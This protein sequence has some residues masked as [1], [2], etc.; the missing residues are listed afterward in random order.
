MGPNITLKQRRPSGFSCLYGHHK[1]ILHTHFLWSICIAGLVELWKFIIR[2]HGLVRRRMMVGN[3]WARLICQYYAMF[4]ALICLLILPVGPQSVLNM[5]WCP[6][7][8][9]SVLSQLLLMTQSPIKR[10][11]HSYFPPAQFLFAL[12][13][14]VCPQIR[15]CSAF[16]KWGAIAKVVEEVF[17]FSRSMTSS[18]TGLSLARRRES[19]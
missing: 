19:N 10:I 7:C 12:A 6:Q 4:L 2:C 14:R 18:G 1:W 3:L 9:L 8:C 17:W 11:F 16:L 15:H 13:K 5:S